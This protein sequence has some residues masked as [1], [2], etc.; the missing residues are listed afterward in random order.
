MNTVTIVLIV[1]AAVL[2]ISLIVMISR[3]ATVKAQLNVS[4][5]RLVEERKS[6]EE[7]LT[8][9]LGEKQEEVDRLRR[10]DDRR[11]QEAIKAQQTLFNTTIEGLKDQVKAATED[12]LQER[13]KE[14]SESSSKQLTDIVDPLKNA[15]KEMQTAMGENKVSQ[16]ALRTEI[17]AQME[18]MIKQ[19]EAAQKSAEELSRAFKHQTKIQGDWGEAKLAELLKSQ[20]FEEGIHFHT[21]YTLQ[22][23]RGNVIKS[24]D[25]H[26][27]RPDIVLRVEPGKD[28]IIDAKVSVSDFIKFANAETDEEAKVHLDAHVKSLEKHVDELAKKDYSRYHYQGDSAIDFVIMFVPMTQALWAAMQAKPTLWRDAMDKRVFIADEQTLYAALRIINK[29]WTKIEQ[30]K[31][32]QHIYELAQNIIDRVGAFLESYDEIGE[33]LNAAAV[34]FNNGKKKLQ[35]SGQSIVKPAKDLIVCG[36]KSKK[37]DKRRGQTV[38]I[39]PTAYLDSEAVL[40]AEALEETETTTDDQKLSNH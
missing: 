1:V 31:N 22:D 17:K 13:Q 40:D 9:R 16:T 35:D 11:H 19:S 27:M 29:T 37:L 5:S 20:G 24:E 3:L 30:E 21:Q 36:L 33:K 7:T 6:A 14:F 34:S 39:I 32:Q 26:N 10:E 15:M 23:E 2:L 25:D 28:I 18:N 8:R 12:M 4:N 38:S